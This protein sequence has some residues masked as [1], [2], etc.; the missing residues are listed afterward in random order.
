MLTPDL[1]IGYFN[2][3]IDGIGNFDGFMVGTS[4]PLLFGG[5]SNTIR[6]SKTEVERQEQDLQTVQ[7]QLKY[8]CD[9][10]VIEIQ[11]YENMINFFE[12]QGADFSNDLLDKVDKLFEEGKIDYVEYLRDLDQA[13]E[14]KTSYLENL[15]NFNESWYQLELLQTEQINKI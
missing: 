10:L 4:I 2:Q 3:Q 6:A 13:I 5:Q 15:Y 11:K 7:L 12:Q 14:L 1:S 9:N 8:Q